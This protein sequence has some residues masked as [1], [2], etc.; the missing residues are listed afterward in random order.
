M[1]M[2][3]LQVNIDL[4]NRHA[5]ESL[6]RLELSHGVKGVQEIDEVWNDIGQILPNAAR[7]HLHIVVERTDTGEF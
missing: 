7:K 1:I 5:R 4:N 2:R 6:A 3:H